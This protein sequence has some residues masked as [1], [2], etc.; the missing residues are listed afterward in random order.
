MAGI[1]P[2]HPHMMRRT[3]AVE[4]I[5]A[6]GDTFS[7]QALLGHSSQAMSR[8]YVSLADDDVATAHRRLSLVER[9]KK[10]R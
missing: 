7:L 9:M 6:G 10:R 4:W 3:T 2:C 1:T 5:R 8:I